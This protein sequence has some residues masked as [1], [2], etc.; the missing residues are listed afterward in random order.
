M[1]SPIKLD[2]TNKVTFIMLHD[3][4]TTITAMLHLGRELAN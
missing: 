1:K 4:I 2:Y 3:S